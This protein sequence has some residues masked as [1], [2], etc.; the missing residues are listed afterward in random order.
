MRERTVPAGRATLCVVALLAA[1]GSRVEAQA[2]RA[3]FL[4]RV[5]GDTLAVETMSRTMTSAE[6]LLRIRTPVLTV[7]QRV[8]ISAANVVAKVTTLVGQGT[9]GDS[10][11]QRA[12]LVFHGDSAVSHVEPMEGAAPIADRRIGVAAGAVPFMNLSGLSIELV[13]RRARAL[14][15]DS[16]R[17]PILLAGGQTLTASVAWQGADSAIIALGNVTL[18]SHTDA[19]GRLLGAEVPSQRLLFERLAA[20]SPAAAWRPALPA[21]VSYAAPEGAPYSAT[22]VTIPARAG[23][24]A[25]TLTMP[26]HARG[27][28]VPAVVLITGSGAQDRDE[29]TP[30]LPEWRPFREFADTLSRRGIAVLRLDDRGVGGSAPP[31]PQATLVSEADDVRDA[32]AWLRRRSGIDPARIGLVGHSSGAAVAPMVAAD[33]GRLRAMVLI[34][35]PASSGRTISEYQIRFIFSDDTTLA[36]ARRDSL[37]GVALRQADSA[38]ATPG[39]LSQFGGYDPLLTARRVRTRTLVLHGETDRQ[40]PVADATRLATAMRN[41]GNRM[42]TLRTFPRLNHLM[43]DDASGSPLR[44]GTL[45]D[46]HVR[47]DLRGALADWLAAALYR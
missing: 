41:A 46:F 38:Y 33:D 12:D 6:A 22:E 5:G 3:V 24:L 20:A 40:V 1:A 39:W 47:P 36:P 25:G 28:R 16:A 42:V 29:S 30:T 18:R 27:A 11:L 7:R 45:P 10:A 35:G 34:A 15:G 31:S 44:Y 37:L 14:G 26:A 21:A 4:A 8:M 23:R 13:L 19:A 43:V 2:E 17:V 9:R 32:V